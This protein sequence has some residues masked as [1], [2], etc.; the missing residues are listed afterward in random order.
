M[1]DQVL[2][3]VWAAVDEVN[4]MASDGNAI[5]K[6]LDTPLLGAD[7]GIDSLSFVNLVVALEDAVRRERNKSVVIVNEETLA[8]EEHPFRTVRSL[9]EY[10]EKLIDD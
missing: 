6:E 5:V 2:E 9:S 7:G 3:I 10:L 4:A 1:T 8:S